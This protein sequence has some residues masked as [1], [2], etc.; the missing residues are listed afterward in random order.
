MN[1][2]Q[3]YSVQTSEKSAGTLVSPND[4]HDFR[5]YMDRRHAQRKEVRKQ[6]RIVARSKKKTK[7]SKPRRRA[8]STPATKWLRELIC[9]LIFGDLTPDGV[10]PSVTKE[11]FT[12]RWNQKLGLP[13]LP[14]YRLL[15]HFSGKDTLYFF[16]NGRKQAKRTLV[17]IDIDVLKS[18][19]LGSPKG[20]GEFANYLKTI[21]PNLYFETSTNGEGLHGYVVLWKSQCD[22]ERTNSAS[23]RL[24]KWLRAEAKKIGA[25]IE[26]VEVK[27]TCPD[28]EFN[29]GLVQAVKY[30]FFAKLPRDVSRF[31]E[32]QDTTSLRVVDLEGEAFDVVEESAPVVA[33]TVPVVST[34][35]KMVAGSVSGKIISEEELASIPQFE[36]LYREWVGPAGLKA[37]KFLV[38]AHDFATAM[39]ILR[40]YKA[41]PNCDGSLPCRRVEKLWTALFVAGDIERPWNHHR[42]KAIRDFLS[43]KGHIDWTEHR[44]E[45]ATVV[46]NGNEETVQ[47][48]IACKWAITDDFGWTLERVSSLPACREGE[49]SF[50]D[51]AIRFLIPTQGN[52]K[53][54]RPTPF[55]LRVEMEQKFWFRAYEALETLYAA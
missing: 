18:K 31:S 9:P 30:G 15:D 45:Y 35:K 10:R 51:T 44:Y 27:G 16:G 38:T 25:D 43:T 33:R 34:T 54:L 37:R 47:K 7:N 11:C 26:Q 28:I 49:A 36:R 22:A 48:G 5:A 1:L 8:A 6:K 42:W 3:Y 2:L 14:N 12:G 46:Q 52:G 20:A 17:M 41:S 50:V 53:N 29:R 4:G 23:K 19:G 55:P 32:W 13:S 21:W 40:H 24:E 39:V